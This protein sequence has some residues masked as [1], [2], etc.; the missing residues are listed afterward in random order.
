MKAITHISTLRLLATGMLLLGIALMPELV[1]AQASPFQ[2]GATALQTNI[3]TL[4]TPVAVIV[5]MILG[6][7]AATGRISWGWP[8]SAL[9]GIAVMFGAPQI[10]AWTRGMFGV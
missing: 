6:V 3:L 9:V 5:V 10:V 2:A 8:I 4:L 7:V 1:L